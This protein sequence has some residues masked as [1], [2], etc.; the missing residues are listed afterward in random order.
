M[1]RGVGRHWGIADKNE[2]LALANTV[3]FDPKR[4][5]AVQ[6]CC[7]AQRCPLVILAL[8]GQQLDEKAE[9]ERSLAPLGEAR[10][11]RIGF[12]EWLRRSQAA[13]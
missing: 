10:L 6:F 8:D 1:T 7:D 9:L 2:I 13:A 11:G 4:S 3:E 12:D 5:L